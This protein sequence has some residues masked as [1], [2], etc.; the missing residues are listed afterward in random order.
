METKWK[1]ICIDIS[2]IVTGALKFI[3]TF[4]VVY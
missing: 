3:L 1:Y 4:E 2:H